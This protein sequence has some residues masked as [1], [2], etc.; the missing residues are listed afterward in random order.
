VK[1]RAPHPFWTAE[2]LRAACGGRLMDGPVD[3]S[4]PVAGVAIDSRQIKPGEA[5]LAIKGD[6]FDGADF[7]DRAIESGASLIIGPESIGARTVPVIAVDDA[8]A[9][10]LR[11]AEIW[12]D[13]IR[14]V[15]VGVTGSNGKTTTVNLI[16]AACSV[17]K[18]GSVS[19]KSFNNHIGAPL[20]VLRADEH[21]DYL[22]CELGTSAPGEIERLARL[23]RPD[24]GVVTGVSLAHTQQLGD[25]DAIRREK[26]AILRVLP[27]DGV[28]IFPH[29]EP[30]LLDG[31]E[32]RRR[33]TFGSAPGADVRVGSV[34]V[35]SG[36]G[37]GGAE[38][39]GIAFTLDGHRE[40]RLP[41]L[42]AH[43]ARNAAAA[44]ACAE[45]IGVGRAEAIEGLAGASIP[46]MRLQS[47][48]VAGVRIIND[49]Y[50]ANPGSM[51]AA[52][53]AVSALPRDGALVLVLGDMLELGEL[54][55]TAHRGVGKA[56]AQLGM[57]LRVVTLGPDSRF[58][59][60]E[61][62]ASPMVERVTA[63]PD[64]SEESIAEAAASLA[65]GD[66]AL[67]KAS[68]GVRLERIIDLLIAQELD[69]TA[70]PAT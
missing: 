14:G 28:A 4:M 30:A 57:P 46:G 58:I 64:W 47:S 18:S 41:L 13:C 24:V 1:T 19:E 61:C 6:R 53:E 16:H 45:Q 54:A 43:N 62:R 15:V 51:K 17:S 50:N 68:R 37:E 70:S 8:G 22:V 5:F 34:S 33:I 67:L 7:V 21:D 25:L 11:L 38:R 31:V 69:P 39:I 56:V 32:A 48:A 65:P 49:A 23:V 52:I 9:A 26:G 44:I 10:L 60:E 59:A 55:E 20:T 40:V 2:G 12:R 3:P 63:L 66:T 36:L 42:G 27:A 29:D 35:D